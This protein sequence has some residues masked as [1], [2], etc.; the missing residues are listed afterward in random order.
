MKNSFLPVCRQDMIN[1]GWEQLDFLVI[2][3]DAYI[4]HSSFGHA[5]IARVLENAG[6]KVGVVA[7]PN[8]RNTEDFLAMGTPKY[9]IFIGSGNIDS[10]VNHYTAAKKKRSTD[11]YS[12]GGKAGY[13]P[14]RAIIVYSNRAREAFPK[15]PVII[16]GIEASLRRFA[17]YDYWDDKVRRS[18]L[19]DA[20]ADLL[21]FGMGETQT[22]EIADQLASG[23]KVEEITDIP[24]TCY[25][26]KEIPKEKC[27]ACFSY[28]EVAKDKVKYA[29]SFMIQYQNQ[30]PFSGK[31]VIQKHGNFYLVQNKPAKPLSRNELDKVYA[32]PYM[33]TYHPMYEKDGGVPAIQ[34]VKFSLTSSRGCFG[35]CSFCA[36]TFHQGRIITSRS[37][38][39]LIQEAEKMVWDPDFKGYIHDV[40]GP[41]ANFRQPSCEKQGIKGSCPKRQC[42][43]P[44]PCENLRVDHTEYAQLLKKL[45]EIPKVKKVFVRS[46]IRYD[47][48]IYDKNDAFFRQLCANHVSGQLKVAPE[49]VSEK[50]LYYMGKPKRQVFDAFCK[51][52][53]QINKELGKEQYV[54]PYLMSSHPGSELKDAIELAEYL[55]DIH[56][57]PEQVQDFYP[58]P[59]TMSTCMFYTGLD[60][61]TMEKVYVP[62]SYEEKKMQRALLQ[63]RRSENYE[64]V[65]KALLK[66]GR[67][68]L[69]G[70]DKHCL[71]PFRPIKGGN[72]NDSKNTRRENGVS[73]NKERTGR[74]SKTIK[75]KRRAAG[76]GGHHRRK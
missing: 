17:H 42:L 8:W 36:L 56:Y 71:I 43:F 13:R 1:R 65:K 59:G 27:F 47:Y 28:E 60:P 35:N 64:I 41:T 32:L 5:I 69:I 61:R 70:F 48:L 73:K 22:V 75:G 30:D 15:L 24:G 11:A 40:G 66:A 74:G 4:D 46:G 72:K 45:S 26:T 31:T 18:V 38:K 33:G 3:G 21:V 50:V 29:Q 10:M 34:E 67:S 9:G 52:Y 20:G 16:G 12:P 49:H 54:V 37:Q 53:T 25:L 2:S 68:D 58:T 39:S 6:Y 14:D 57:T 23:T 7:Q 44:E 63:Y 62:K 76:A 51:K 55:R 19:V